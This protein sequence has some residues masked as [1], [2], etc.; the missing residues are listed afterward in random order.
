MLTLIYLILILGVLVFIHEFGHFIA[1][2]ACHVYITEFALGMGPKI[3]SF[4]RKKKNDPTV[5]SLR[6]FPIGGYCAMAGE[7]DED[8]NELNLKKEEYMCNKSKWQ[9]FLIL[10]AGVTMNIILAFIILFLQS[11]IWGTGEQKSVIGEIKEG[12]PIADAGIEVGDTV[13]GLNGYRI[14]TWDKLTLVINL[15][16]ES[17]NYEFEIKKANGEL[18]KYNITPKVEKDADGVERSIFGLGA[19]TKV[20]KGV[21][22]ALKYAFVKLGAIV[23]SMWLIIISLIKGTLSLSALSGPVGMYTVVGESA[24]LGFQNILYL[25]GYLSINLAVINALPFPAFDGGRILFV[26]IE[27]IKGSKVNPKVE[28]MFH[29]IGFILLMALMIY[30][31]IQD[32]IRLF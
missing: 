7:V 31:T 14:N 9:R 20:Y 13:V 32:I 4:K 27:A 8:N 22:N 6:L 12:Y 18:K 16:N 24:K 5:Y 2:K 3:F 28:N 30:I 11:L 29:T 19:G 26:I 17:N 15:K 21:S 23:S 1:A 25:T 10:I